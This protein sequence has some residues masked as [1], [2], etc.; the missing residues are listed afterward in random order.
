MDL[1]V[2]GLDDLPMTGQSPGTKS[3]HEIKL[4][5]TGPTPQKEGK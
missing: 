3:S 5:S 1:L 2:K 4:K